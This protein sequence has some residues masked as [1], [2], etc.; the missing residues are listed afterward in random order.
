MIALAP[1]LFVAQGIRFFAD[2]LLQCRVSA[3]A[4]PPK[5]VSS[6]ATAMLR[7]NPMRC[8][9]WHRRHAVPLLEGVPVIFHYLPCL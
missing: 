3:V 5:P 2:Q 1:T 8:D 6:A 7:I 9:Y 4:P